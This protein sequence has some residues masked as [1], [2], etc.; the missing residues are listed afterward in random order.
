[1]WSGRRRKEYLESRLPDSMTADITGNAP[2]EIKELPIKWLALF[3]DKGKGFAAPIVSRVKVMDVSVLPS[4][5][6]P[7]RLEGKVTCEIDVTQGIVNAFYV[8][9]YCHQPKARNLR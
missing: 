3:H 7:L 9:A 1:M 8:C 4:M 2:I 6:D 5:D